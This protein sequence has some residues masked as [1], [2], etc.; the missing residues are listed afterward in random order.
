MIPTNITKDHILMAIADIDTNGLK[1]ASVDSKVHELIYNN[2]SYPPKYI[3]SIANKFANGRPLEHG[4]LNTLMAQKYLTK[5]SPDFEIRSDKTGPVQ[6]LVEDYKQ[7]LV[8]TALKEEIYNWE[9]LAKYKGRPRLDTPDF[10]AEIL[11]IDY[12]NLIFYSGIDV[13]NKLAKESPEEYAQAFRI[14]FDE[15]VD[16]ETR[17]VAFQKAVDNIYRLAG[18]TLKHHHDERTIATFLTFYNP[19]IYSLYKDSFYSKYCKLLNEKPA[20]AGKKYPHYLKLVDDFIEKYVKTDDE[21]LEM[22]RSLLPGTAYPDTN[23]K[24][25]AQ[26]IFY[27]ML[28]KKEQSFS[29]V[30][31]ELKASMARDESIL[32]KFTFGKKADR[33]KEKYT[34]IGDAEGIIGNFSA[35]FEVS[36][37]TRDKKSN[38]YFVDIHFEGPDQQN[39]FSEFGKRFGDLPEKCEWIQWGKAKSIGYK[40]GIDPTDDDLID[41]IKEA[42][43]YLEDNVGNQIRSIMQMKSGEAVSQP[44]SKHPLNQILFGP[45]GTGKT[46]S[47]IEKAL[48][49]IGEEAEQNLNWADRTAVQTQFQKRVSEE[50]IIFTTFHQSMSYED[51]IEGIKPATTDNNHVIYEIQ[52][53]IFKKLCLD[54]QKKEIKNSNF[55]AVYKQ[56]LNEIDHADGN[57][58]ILETLVR[59]KEFTIYKNSNNNIKF[60]AN[61][62]K[63]YEGVIKKEVLE[64]YLKTGEA[65]DWAS[66]TKALG[67]YVKQKYKYNQAVE[68]V[69]GNF[70]LIIDEINR[71]N[72]SQ[73]FGELITLIED[74]KRLGK[75]EQLYVTLPYSKDVFG[76]PSNLY[77]IGTMN[78]ADRSVEALDAALRRRFV[79]HEIAPQGSL[80]TKEGLL[81]DQR[82]ILNGIELE[83]LLNKINTRI[84]VLLNRDHLIGHSF[85]MQV[86]SIEKLTEAFQ[87]KI[88]P[89]L[90]EYFYGDYGKIGLVLG[91]GFV[92]AK[93][94]GGNTVFARFN[95]YDSSVLEGKIIYEIVDYT[96]PVN[97]TLEIDGQPVSMNF[98]KAIELLFK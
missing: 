28:D 80:I 50:R 32:S 61:T 52:N 83:S 26:D 22:L 82:G 41:K 11:A 74:N 92:R 59:A 46:Y 40:E 14:L 97:Y 89:L 2:K 5:L 84:E 43:L 69:D 6:Q 38:F 76:V 4:E 78:T 48:R 42:L 49:I 25:L 17:I 91:E 8:E 86:N 79:F 70:V 37:L 18:G 3:V 67:E 7:Y 55:E 1:D 47:T 24:I 30:I 19:D 56:L 68:S 44:R 31:E 90:Q 13:K 75:E 15:S 33:I 85:F 98:E 63:A 27:R 20:Q 77:I 95:N 29:T 21:L 53:G 72:M 71:G 39:Y 81:R 12:G 64:Q 65:S 45:P 57:K 94:T 88:I 54:A 36:T 35:H 60:H 16:L 62:E 58:L 10:G 34:W 87:N 9:L 73:I 51:F 23:H 66:Y 93:H 96:Q